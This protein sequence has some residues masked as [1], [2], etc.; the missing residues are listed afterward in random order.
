MFVVFLDQKPVAL[1]PRRFALVQE[2]LGDHF[3][4]NTFW[5]LDKPP[6]A[7]SRFQASLA[8]TWGRKDGTD[9]W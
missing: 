9:C 5:A 2:T 4:R 1:V 6:W 7:I 8:G 3:S